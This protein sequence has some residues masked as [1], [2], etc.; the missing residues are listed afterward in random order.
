MAE[1]IKN[2]NMQNDS[3]CVDSV[4]TRDEAFEELSSNFT[5]K[6]HYDLFNAV[7]AEPMAN[8]SRVCW[9]NE[10]GRNN[11]SKKDTFAPI[12]VEFSKWLTDYKNL[13][14]H[15]RLSVSDIVVTEA[16]EMCLCGVVHIVNGLNGVTR[17][18]RQ[19]LRHVMDVISHLEDRYGGRAWISSTISNNDVYYYLVTFAIYLD[20]LKK[21]CCDC[22]NVKR[23]YDFKELGTI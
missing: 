2:K 20:E 1:D 13:N 21:N 9:L 5:R 19:S 16:S 12:M 18:S 6:N 22:G 14:K 11:L 3:W 7:G 10:N 15:E 23:L 17:V 4:L 8:I